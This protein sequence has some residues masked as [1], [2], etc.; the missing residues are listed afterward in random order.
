MKKINAKYYI[1]GYGC[2]FNLAE[3]D[4]IKDLFEEN[5]VKQTSSPERA[6][7]LLVNTCAVKDT[8]EQRMLFRLK[9]LAHQKR[10]SAR[11]FAF[12]CLAATRKKII[13]ST[14]PEI[15]VL[16]TDLES[17]C[18]ALEFELKKF[19]PSS[20]NGKENSLVS[21]IPV[22]LGC[23]GAC[24]YCA[25]K[26]ARGD[27]HSYSLKSIN[28]SFKKDAKKNGEIWLTSQ[29]M[30]CYGF[31]IKSNLPKLMELLLKTQGKYFVRIGM[32]NPN[33]FLRRKKEIM[34]I[35]NNKKVFH[36]LHL[37]LQSGS[38]KILKKMNRLYSSDEFI[39][40]VEFARKKCPGITIATD[41]IAG[42]PGE[43]E[44]DF[45][46]TIRVLEITRPDL[47]N[48]SRYAKRPDTKAAKMPDQ[49]TESQKKERTKVLTDL[50]NKILLE[51]K[52][53]LVGFEFEAFVS[54][55]KPK[56]KFVA[57]TINY[58]P[59]IVDSNYGEKVRVKLTEAST[60]FFFGEIIK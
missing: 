42:F 24:T 45:A 58:L 35:F 17:L 44:K 57:R 53:K 60:H 21:I 46:A 20:K 27:L 48:I 29:D 51:N 6:D 59:V 2:S 40:S 32:M 33:H 31:D 26:L 34:E 1:E 30:G 16:D 54:E 25:T 38:D 9:T 52:N 11:L 8:T 28:E 3:T 19:S 56:G 14:S 49:L 41:V 55:K 5:K 39:K 18:K 4:Q 47:I 43:T 37:P 23:L 50:R 7:I 22:S 36:F 10:A 15:I 12:G 13:Q